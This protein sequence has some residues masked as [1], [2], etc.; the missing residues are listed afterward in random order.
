[1][2][3]SNGLKG[4]RRLTASQAWREMQRANGVRNPRPLSEMIRDGARHCSR[5]GTGG[6][7]MP[8]LSYE[9]S[10]TPP[11]TPAEPIAPVAPVVEPEDGD[12]PREMA[13]PEEGGTA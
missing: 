11:I 13:G 12:N 7:M 4:H 1:M 5:G 3:R 10:P 8:I 2:A 6:A 9:P